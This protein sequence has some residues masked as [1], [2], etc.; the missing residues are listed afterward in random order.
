MT[1]YA[2]SSYF[3]PEDLAL[4]EGV[5]KIFQA[6]PD[7]D[8]GKDEKGEQNLV[9]CHMVAR[10][11]AKIFPELKVVDGS[12]G[13]YGGYGHSWLKRGHRVIIDPYPW[14]TV[15]GP[16]MVCADMISPWYCLYQEFCS[17]R[18]TE[19]KKKIENKEFR[20]HLRK[21]SAAVKKT[22]KELGHLNLSTVDIKGG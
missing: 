16:I 5:K 3:S 2:E 12:F 7:V 20:G 1:P 13:A 14:A 18:A 8:L 22:A 6:M 10:A 19:F 9:S 17:C 4:F 21:V 11:I 15:G